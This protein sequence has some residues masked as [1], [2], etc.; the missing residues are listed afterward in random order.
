LELFYNSVCAVIE[1][2]NDYSFTFIFVDDGS[3]DSTFEV[4][5]GLAAQDTRV[6]YIL[7]SR[8]FGKEAAMFAGLSHSRGD[9]AVLMDADGQDPPAMIPQM[10]CELENGYD[11]C[12]TRRVTRKGE[13]ALRSAF[14]RA[15]YR[16]INRAADVEI[17]DGARDFRAMKDYVVRAVVS[18]GEVERFSK[19]L[20]SW[21][22]F[23]TKW[24]EYENI[25]RAAGET[26]WSFAKLF[27]YA[28]G[29]MVSFSAW[30]LRFASYS[31]AGISVFSLGFFVYSL[32]KNIIRKNDVPGYAS[33]M[34]MLTFLGGIILLALGILGEYVARIYM[35]TKRRPIYVAKSTNIETSIKNE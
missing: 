19:G 35:E 21:V 9:I 20:F 12:A 6:K 10:L 27:G 18:L 28:I 26:K 16:L 32:V 24:L 1:G 13:P 8:N 30:P 17:V 23:S 25:E 14:A 11:V 3:W 22:G 5:Q 34:V 29:G 4:V 15:F 7:F 2:M 33:T 31:G